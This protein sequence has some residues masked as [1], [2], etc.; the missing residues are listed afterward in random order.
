MLQAQ[1][2]ASVK[3]PAMRLPKRRVIVVVESVALAAPPVKT[4]PAAPVALSAPALGAE[5]R[6]LESVVAGPLASA[7][8]GAAAGGDAPTGDTSV[9]KAAAGGGV[10]AARMTLDDWVTSAT[11]GTVY[12]LVSTSMVV[13]GW[14]YVVAGAVAS[15]GTASASA[16][17]DDG[18]RLDATMASVGTAGASL[19][20]TGTSGIDVGIAVTTAGFDGT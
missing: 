19:G 1:V 6:L 3:T 5:T 10:P 15:T 18:E 11:C 8:A 4:G 2:Y 12:L 9:A 13:I 7:T 17:D 16:T 20:P 14:A